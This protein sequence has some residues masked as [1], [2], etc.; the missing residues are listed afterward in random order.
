MGTGAVRLGSK[1]LYL[2]SHLASPF[3]TFKLNFSC[4][5]IIELYNL[6]ILD[7]SFSSDRKRVCQVAFPAQAA[8]KTGGGVPTSVRTGECLTHHL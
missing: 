7:C 4:L 5:F 6:H 2:S 3:A 1:H 8:A